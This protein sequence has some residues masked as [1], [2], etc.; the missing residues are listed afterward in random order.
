MSVALKKVEGIEGVEVSLEKGSADIR[1]KR[2]NK[3]TLPQLRRLIRSTGYQTKDAQV[4]ARGQVVDRAGTPALDLLNGDVIVLA[5]RPTDAPAA[6]VE[7]I[8]VSR[9]KEDNSEV[10]TIKSIK[11]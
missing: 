5:E 6:A 4:T 8:G 1:L 7:V 9:A 10:L 2:E 3:V 11:P